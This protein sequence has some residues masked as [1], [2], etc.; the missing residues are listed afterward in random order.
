MAVQSLAAGGLRLVS[1]QLGLELQLHE[2]RL[3]LF[4]P[5]QQKYLPTLEKAT[6]PE[7]QAAR[8]AA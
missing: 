6:T 4:G 2:G 3:W 1:D 5:A 7:H 8:R